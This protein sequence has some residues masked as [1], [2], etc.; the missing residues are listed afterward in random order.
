MGGRLE[1]VKFLCSFPGIDVHSPVEKI[2]N[3]TPLE[4]ARS[5]GH[6]EIVKFLKEFQQKK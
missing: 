1:M 3:A 4:I 5:N 2:Q 6:F